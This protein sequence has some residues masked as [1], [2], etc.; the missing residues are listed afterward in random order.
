[1][2]GNGGSGL[3]ILRFMVKQIVRY[4]LVFAAFVSLVAAAD[5]SGK[6]KGPL[7]GGE[8]EIQFTFKVEADALSGTM[9]GADGKAFPLK[10]KL[11]G[12]KISFTVESEYQGTPVKLVLNGTVSGEEMKLTV[13]TADGAW[14][15]TVTAKKQQE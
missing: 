1:V 12:D 6:W 7:D 14:S 13:G 10:G 4:A 5:V 11:D 9:S 8:G 3:G 15:S 2:R